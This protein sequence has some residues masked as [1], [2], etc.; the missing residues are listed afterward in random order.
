M[1]IPADMP[2]TGVLTLQPPANVT[3][4]CQSA[5]CRKRPG[6]PNWI[7]LAVSQICGLQHYVK[8]IYN[9]AQQ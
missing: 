4:G 5:E 7:I 8:E 6:Y 3:D 1:D 2:A 9:G